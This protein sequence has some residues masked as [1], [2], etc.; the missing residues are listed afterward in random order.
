MLGGGEKPKKTEKVASKKTELVSQ[1]DILKDSV[2][3]EKVTEIKKKNEKVD[4]RLARLGIKVP[5]FIA[6]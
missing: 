6:Q 4:R 2:H 3:I 5:G 1:T